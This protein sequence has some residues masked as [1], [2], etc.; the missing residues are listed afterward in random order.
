[1]PEEKSKMFQIDIGL[2]NNN[3]KKHI[4]TKEN[5]EILNF[6]DKKIAGVLEIWQY[7]SD[8]NITEEQRLILSNLCEINDEKK[9]VAYRLYLDY[10]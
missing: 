4:L 9:I 1:M 3:I 10:V 5:L 8:G 6:T 7:Y 2:N